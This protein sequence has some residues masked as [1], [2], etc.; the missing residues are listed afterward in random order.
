MKGGVEVD[1]SL[2]AEMETTWQISLCTFTNAVRQEVAK[3]SDEMRGRAC[4][5]SKTDTHILR[6]PV[7]L[8]VVDALEFGRFGGVAEADQDEG[9][10]WRR[11]PVPPVVSLSL[12]C[13]TSWSSYLSI[14]TCSMSSRAG[15]MNDSSA[16]AF[17][18]PGTDT[19]PTAR[20]SS[21]SFALCF[22]S[23]VLSSAPASR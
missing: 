21:S 14:L 15:A 7:R 4:E 6:V 3:H 1:L 12:S 8:R 2:A 16:A 17:K 5:G 9:A 18:T 11:V 23:C 20:P 13:R 22:S 10:I 19:N